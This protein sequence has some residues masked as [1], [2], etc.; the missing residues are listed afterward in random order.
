M[1]NQ[2]NGVLMTTARLH[3]APG[4]S[5]SACRANEGSSSLLSVKLMR[6][7]MI[8]SKTGGRT[9]GRTDGQAYTTVTDGAYYY[10]KESVS[11]RTHSMMGS[12]SKTSVNLTKVLIKD[13]HI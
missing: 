6:F 8:G 7:P 1:R 12:R 2:D 5:S 13:G 10:S 9:D 4:S 3:I 11:L